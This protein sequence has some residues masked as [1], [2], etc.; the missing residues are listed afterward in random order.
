[1]AFCCLLL[2]ALAAGFRRRF[3]ATAPSTRPAQ[4]AWLYGGAALGGFAYLGL[5]QVALATGLAVPADPAAWCL[6][7]SGNT[8]A[9]VPIE[10]IAGPWLLRSL[11]LSGLCLALLVAAVDGLRRTE[12]PTPMPRLLLAGAAGMV[13][14]LSLA[15]HHGFRLYAFAANGAWLDLSLYLLPIAALAAALWNLRRDVSVSSPG[16]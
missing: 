10:A 2:I 14:V 8:A 7:G 16:I 5:V 4:L 11:L 1:V 13:L 12:I 3:G 9:A 15:D 6:G